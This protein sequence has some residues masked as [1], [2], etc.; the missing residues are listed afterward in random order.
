MSDTQNLGSLLKAARLAA[1]FPT[2]VAWVDYLHAQNFPYSPEAYGHWEANRRRP[3]RQT[4]LT[5]AQHLSRRGGLRDLNQVNALLLAAERPPLSPEEQVTQFAH[6]RRGALSPNLPQKWH[7]LL[8]GRE[9]A[10]QHLL[11]Y[12]QQAHHK[13]VVVISGLGGIGKTALAY[14]LALAALQ[15]GRFEHLLWESAKMEEFQSTAATNTT[16]LD[17]P[18]LLRSFARQLGLES[19][20]NQ[21]EGVLER[22]LRARFSQG[23]Y[24]LVLDNL[25]T[26]HGAQALAA[27]LHHLLGP[28]ATSPASAVLMTSRE[29]LLKETQ[30]YDYHLGGLKREAG[31]EFL[32]L[33][34]QLRGSSLAQAPSTLAAPLDRICGGMPLAIKLLVSHD[35]F[36][37]PIEESLQALEQSK[38]EKEI[39]RFIYF[40]LWQKLD[41]LPRQVLIAIGR[42]SISLQQA[43]LLSLLQIEGPGLQTASQQL[44][45]ASLLELSPAIPPRYDIHAMTRWFVR[46]PLTAAWEAHKRD[47]AAPPQL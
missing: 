36:H 19:L 43:H 2:Q 38:N 32:R 33:E 17:W 42:A 6:L 45:I 26:F 20:V 7:E 21:E 47:Q 13:R 1:G 39:Y 4:L 16:P 22:E 28:A 12:W 9:E 15:S 35:L 44:Q 30:V 24:L 25:E 3:D 27:K 46:G 41:S 11:A 37:I 10:L 8:L 5:L 29:R 40:S 31:F 23:A 18:S 14:E 34:A